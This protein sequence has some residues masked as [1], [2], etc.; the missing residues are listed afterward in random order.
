[1]ARTF[2]ILATV[3]GFLGVALGAF[4]A[5]GLAATFE[6]N[7]G[8]EDTYQTAAQYQMVHALA[9]LGIGILSSQYT[10]PS[11]QRFL[12]F[13]G[14]LFVTG[15]LLFSGSLYI[16][17]VFNLRFMGAIAPLGGAA[18]LG[19]WLCLGLTFRKVAE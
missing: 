16:L 13:A 6:A 7:P 12:R 8:N 15:I 14:W 4:G 17:S 2:L 10:A 1:M 3:F 19:G 5:H 11:Q 9:L 18:M